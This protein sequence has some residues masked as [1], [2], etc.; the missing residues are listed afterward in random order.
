MRHLVLAIAVLG[1]MSGSCM[2]SHAPGVQALGD[3]ACYTCHKTDFEMAPDHVGRSTECSNCHR[4]S[5]WNPALLDHPEVE[6]PIASGAHKPAKCLVCHDLDSPQPSTDGANT[7][8]I[9][10]HP[11]NSQ[12]QTNHTGAVS[13][14][15]A[16]YAYDSATPN[17]CLTCHPKGTAG[18]HP[19]NLFPRTGHHAVPCL[20]CHIRADG[21]DDD[22]A[23]TS[24]IEA[25]CHH[26][27]AW[28]DREH[29]GEVSGYSSRRGD[30]SNKHFCLQCHQGG[31]GG[32]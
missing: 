5:S 22:G 31:R 15:G 9:Q 16:P 18:K 29:N 23:N 8:C 1:A 11:N 3:E 19:D 2:E 30:G 10:C 32:D 28:S 14:T 13:L 25:G 20:S 24:C 21:P 6:F 26:T 4:T 12:Q 27:L 7:N 17:F